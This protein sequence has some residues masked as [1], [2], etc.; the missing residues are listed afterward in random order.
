MSRHTYAR[1]RVASNS[2]ENIHPAAHQVGCHFRQAVVFTARPSELDHN[3]LALDK[4]AL[5]QAAAE[6]GEQV[7]GVLR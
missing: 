1:R 7:R 2:G 3:I 5:G 4:A 6:C